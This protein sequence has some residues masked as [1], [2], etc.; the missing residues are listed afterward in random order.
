[1]GTIEPATFAD[2][3]AEARLGL[4]PVRDQPGARSPEPQLAV[5]SE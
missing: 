5:A 2:V 4:Q 3:A 1:M